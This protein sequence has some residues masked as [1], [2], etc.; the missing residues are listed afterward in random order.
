MGIFIPSTYLGPAPVDVNCTDGELRLANGFSELE[1]RVE[2]CLN[3]TWGPVCG[4]QWD[5][6]DANVVCRQL[7]YIPL[8]NVFR[9]KYVH[10]FEFILLFFL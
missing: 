7:G 10:V 2:I 9:Y 3:D 1:G 8:G 5:V 4:N 6:P